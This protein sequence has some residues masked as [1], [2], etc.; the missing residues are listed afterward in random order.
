MDKA[1]IQGIIESRRRELKS[2]EEGIKKDKTRINSGKFEDV[3]V[4]CRRALEGNP[5][6]SGAFRA[7][8][9]AASAVK[10][11]EL[12]VY[13]FEQIIEC[14]PGNP[15]DE[16]N[17]GILYF[18][19]GRELHGQEN[20]EAAR[21]NLEKSKKMLEGYVGK[22]E[23]IQYIL[24]NIDT[25]IRIYRGKESFEKRE[26]KD[27]EEGL[28]EANVGQSAKLDKEDSG[29]AIN[30]RDLEAKLD[31]PKENKANRVS[32]ARKLSDHFRKK[33][34]YK[35]ALK[36][37]EKALPLDGQSDTK[38]AIA[39]LK[40]EGYRKSDSKDLKE[41]TKIRKEYEALIKKGAT[42]DGV[43]LDLG[44]INFTLKRWAECITALQGNIP[45]VE[46]DKNLAEILIG[47]SLSNMHLHQAAELQF[48]ETASRTRG[49]KGSRYVEAMYGLGISQKAL[50]KVEEA[51]KSFSEV[52]RLDLRYEDALDHLKSLTDKN[53]QK[54][55]S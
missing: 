24:K 9:K 29:R 53:S 36:Y 51:I 13:A 15:K 40:Y 46:K 22:D 50:R 19:H 10:N 49:Q 52:I 43:T 12:A 7:L 38:K 17:L 33:G 44:T 39:R 32:A 37:L 5:W 45:S 35:T 55:K 4:Q 26:G 27:S 21:E 8:G 47:S 3:Y 23:T 2:W 28:L 6:D 18:N 42:D 34:K 1:E 54:P 30:R 20:Y 25:E 16:A 11:Y 48:E 41:L 31:D 14:E